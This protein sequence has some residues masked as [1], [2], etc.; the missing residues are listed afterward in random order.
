MADAYR[1]SCRGTACCAR[2][3]HGIPSRA[4]ARAILDALCAYLCR[5]FL[6]TAWAAIRSYR[7]VSTRESRQ[8]LG[9]HKR[10]ARNVLRRS[11]LIR[12]VA[13]AIAARNKK[14]RHRSDTRHKKRIMISATNHLHRSEIMLRASLRKRV[15][16]RR[17]AL[18]RC[19]RVHDFFANRNLP[20]RRNRFLCGFDFTHH[21][22]APR[23]TCIANVEGQT[24]RGSECC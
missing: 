11:V 23:K 22:I 2:L 19:I 16:N 8:R 6:T 21:R 7:M 3:V 4:A 12:P 17:S 20:L 9:K 14:H 10:S 1:L 18:R 13:V 24:E 15:D 5:L